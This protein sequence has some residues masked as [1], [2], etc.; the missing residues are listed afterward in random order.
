VIIEKLNL[1]DLGQIF[2]FI[3]GDPILNWS[4]EKLRDCL[5]HADYLGFSLKDKDTILGYVL[6]NVAGDE[7]HIMHIAV[8]PNYRH[9]G[10]ATQLLRFAIEE[11]KTLSKYQ[12]I[13][14]VRIDNLPAIKLYEKNGFIKI[15]ERKN[16][17]HACGKSYN[18][19]VY[20][21]QL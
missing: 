15:G 11:I 5:Q 10:Y 1:T 2:T 4:E 21:Y 18:A 13:L 7:A 14:E 16:Y 19:V 8:H 17:Y 20:S 12:I 3:V 6:L 9:Q